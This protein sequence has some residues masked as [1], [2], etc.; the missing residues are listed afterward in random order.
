MT[1]A[2]VDLGKLID[3]NAAER[4]YCS[5]P[6]FA[7]SLIYARY[8][9]ENKLH[10]TILRLVEQVISAQDANAAR[11]ER[12]ELLDGLEFILVRRNTKS[13]GSENNTP[14]EFWVRKAV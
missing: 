8:G 13:E 4:G 11:L 9:D 10:A 12:D 14:T 3:C 6:L 1:P 2:M 7:H 5:K